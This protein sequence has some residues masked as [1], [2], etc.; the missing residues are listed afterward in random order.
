[1]G[2]SPIAPAN[3]IKYEAMR[4]KHGYRVVYAEVSRKMSWSDHQD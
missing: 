3:R 2:S 4:P 1:M